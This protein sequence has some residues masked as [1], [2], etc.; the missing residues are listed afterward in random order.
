MPLESKY[1]VDEFIITAMARQFSGEVLV[2]SVTAFGALSARLAK[3]LY[4]PDLAVLATP[5]SGME[6]LPM[7]TLTLGQFLTDAQSGI[8]LSMEEIFDAIFTDR[9]RIW[10]N[11]AQIDQYGNT[12]ITCIGD[13]HRPKVAMVGSRGIPEDTSHLSQIFYY[14]LKHERSVVK[15]VDFRSG[16][17]NG[18]ERDRDL[19]RYG[20]PTVLVS[21][22]GVFN[23][24]GPGGAMSVQ[25][26][27]PGV[28]LEE[29][30]EKSGFEVHAPAQIPVT[31]EPTEEDIRII[32]AA[33]PLEVR[34]WESL[35]GSQAA[36]RFVNVYER[37]R[38]TLHATWPQLK[39]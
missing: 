35:S 23:F 14:V 20:A 2:S 34:K 16:A 15:V 27:H 8:P 11:P 22:L 30:N 3:A 5:E 32:R 38:Q 28:T 4:A 25:S 10:I 29:V 7:P 31:P 37:E 24:T 9:F 12:N 17:G 26:L 33:D 1:S 39:R 13:W 36:E 18:P 19:G 21:D 6:V